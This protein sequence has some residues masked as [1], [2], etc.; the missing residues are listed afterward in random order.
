MQ[1]TKKINSCYHYITNND[2]EEENY[3]NVNTN[4]KVLITTRQM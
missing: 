4:K 2:D 3:L 1:K